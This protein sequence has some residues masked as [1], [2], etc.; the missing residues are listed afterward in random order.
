MKCGDV[1]TV[2]ALATTENRDQQSAEEY[3]RLRGLD[4]RALPVSEV[5]DEELAALDNV[6]IPAEAAHYD[7]EL[8]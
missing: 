4:R 3:R 5:T 8:A 1:V 2:A 6:K 7:D